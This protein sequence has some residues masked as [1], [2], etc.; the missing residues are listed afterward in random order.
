[1]NNLETEKQ[2][3]TRNWKEKNERYLKK[4]QQFFDVAE[5]IA[6]E[7]LRKDV[8]SQMLKCDE[9]L[10]IIAEEYFRNLEK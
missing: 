8:I 3:Y 7:Q 6:D 4:L 2:E 5:N 1:M 10:T 9:T